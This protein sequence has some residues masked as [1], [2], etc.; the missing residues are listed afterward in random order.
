MI[1]NENAIN[2]LLS[3]LYSRHPISSNFR[4]ELTQLL[5]HQQVKPK[6][7]LC[8]YGNH[9]TNIWYSVD[10]WIVAFQY[11]PFTNEEVIAIYPPS[12]IFTEPQS[13]LLQKPSEQRLMV[14]EGKHLLYISRSAFTSLGKLPETQHLLVHSL[15]LGHQESQ[16][17]ISLMAMNNIQKVD[18]FAKRYPINQLPGTIVASFLRMT[19]S[20]YSSERAKYNRNH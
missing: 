16:W 19:Q 11:F 4:M 3:L 15:L 1:T 17:R 2:E 8:N 12:S 9:V 7:Q 5:D 6:Q 14:L 10:C 20:S 18:E 13:F